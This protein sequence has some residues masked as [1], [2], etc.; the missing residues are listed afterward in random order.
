MS[1]AVNQ[2]LPEQGK[3]ASNPQQVG[4]LLSFLAMT[5]IEIGVGVLTPRQ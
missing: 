4:A 2:L 5:S 3:E 1:L